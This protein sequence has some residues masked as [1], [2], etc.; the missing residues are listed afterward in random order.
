[1]NAVGKNHLISLLDTA[2]TF[3]TNPNCCGW[4]CAGLHIACADFS[5]QEWEM[6]QQ[7]NACAEKHAETI[8]V[9]SSIASVFPKSCG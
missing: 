4:V 6:H 7:G 3:H 5:N 9:S 2:G 8:T 1:M